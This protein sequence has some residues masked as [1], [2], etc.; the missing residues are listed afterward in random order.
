MRASRSTELR[1]SAEELPGVARIHRREFLRRSAASVASFAFGG[2]HIF[3]ARAHPF[4]VATFSADVTPPLGHALMGGGIAPAQRIHDPLYA[5]GLVL[6][7][8]GKPVVVVAVD[9]C[10]IRNDAYER[11]RTVLAQAARTDRERVLV[12]SVHVHD[13]P[14]AD[15]EAQ[16]ILET[17][18]A[19][20]S[21]CDLAFH[22]QAVQR[23]AESMRTSLRSPGRITHFGTGQAKVERVA[24]N[25]RYLLPTGGRATIA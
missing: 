11:W 24:S 15:L 23:A 13:A 7:G 3:A 19:S 2:S 21:I 20:G 1:N 18:A 6:L 9:W 14:I 8:A 10:E 17:H 12:T 25:R 4:Q 22:E 16:R 5:R